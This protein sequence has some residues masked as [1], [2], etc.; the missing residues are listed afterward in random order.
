M[1]AAGGIQVAIS[2]NNKTPPPTP[3]MAV[4]IEVAAEASSRKIATVGL[5]ASGNRIRSMELT[6][7][8]A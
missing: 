3:R 6:L 7:G 2:T 5:R 4:N 1:I 8:L